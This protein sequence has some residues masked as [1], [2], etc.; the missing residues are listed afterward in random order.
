MEAQMANTYF[1]NDNGFHRCL[2]N[3]G[4]ENLMSIEGAGKE[5]RSF[6]DLIG[7]FDEIECYLDIEGNL[8]EV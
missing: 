1:D 2:F 7:V 3:D 4:Y 8:F 5:K 6:R